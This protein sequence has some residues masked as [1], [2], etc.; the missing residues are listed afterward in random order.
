MIAAILFLLACKSTTFEEDTGDLPP[1]TSGIQ[2]Y[3]CS[4]KT[5]STISAPIKSITIVYQIWDTNRL[6]QRDFDYSNIQKV[7]D[8]LASV[9]FIPKENYMLDESGNN[10]WLIFF[11]YVPIK[12]MY[13]IQLA[14]EDV[15][16]IGELY[17]ASG[18][19]S[20]DTLEYSLSLPSCDHSG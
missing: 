5:D 20:T 1:Q 19:Y 3:D 10:Y 12:T 8:V 15:R 7:T 14:H 16:A 18:R 17:Y 6:L 2:A 13:P 4:Y 11:E 9:T